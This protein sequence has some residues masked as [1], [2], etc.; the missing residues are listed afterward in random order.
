M[1]I[2]SFFFFFFSSRRRH[3]R[4]K[5]DWS[6]DVCSSD[7]YQEGCGGCTLFLIAVDVEA[8]SMVAPEKQLFHRGGIAVEVD[9]HGDIRCEQGFKHLAIQAMWMGGLFLQYEEIGDVDHAYAQLGHLIAQ[10]MSGCHDLQR[11]V[12][13][14]THQYDIRVNAIIYAG[15]L[16][17]RGAGAAVSN[18]IFNRE[19]LGHRRLVRNDQVDIVL[20]AQAVI[21]GTD[22]AI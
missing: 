4:F 19:P 14:D 10:D 11:W 18:S 3:T 15:P 22:Q 9:D 1:R 13:A 8:T 21:H 5:C 17:D 6:S 7:L 20:A 2:Q 16:P 12:I